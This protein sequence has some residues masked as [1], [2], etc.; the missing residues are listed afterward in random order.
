MSYRFNAITIN[1]L[2]GSFVDIDKQI[3]IF[4]WKGK[5]TIIAKL[6]G[7]NKKESHS[8]T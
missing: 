6:W 5:G 7:K 4:V 8:L 1:I 2:A 3:L